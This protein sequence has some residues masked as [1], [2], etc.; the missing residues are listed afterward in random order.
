MGRPTYEIKLSASE[1]KSLIKQIQ[2]EPERRFADRLRVILSKANGQANQA[3]AKQLQMGRKQVGKILRQYSQGGISAL[4]QKGERSG[5]QAKL[6]HEQQQALKVELLTKIY[7]TAWQVIAWVFDQWQIEYEV[8]AMQKLLKRL[9]FSYK[10][11][12]LLPSKADPELQRQFVIWYQGLCQRLG[13]DDRIYFGDAAH[14][15]HNAEAG[16]AW[17]LLG[18]PHLIPS[19]SGRQRYNVLG[20]YSPHSHQFVGLLTQDNITQDKLC[21]LLSALRSNHPDHA[22]LYLILDNARY[23]YTSQVCDQAHR[24]HIIL[25][26]LPPYSPNLNPIER[27]W[28]F[29]RKQ[30]FKDKYRATF[31]DFCA[32]LDQ[33]F[34]ELAL[35]RPQ[36]QS[37]ITHKFEVL[38]SSWNTPLTH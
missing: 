16:Y 22:Q 4:R 26:F 33:F 17:S 21:E 6:N 13:P 10:K 8:S 29:V 34:D 12:R 20:A 2:N 38:P 1:R 27:L 19:N 5:S 32:Q 37:L 36:L 24:S 14:F 23:N 31:A 35:Y 30:F 7:A 28:K 9:G 11:N 15:K 3:I 18:A 25:D